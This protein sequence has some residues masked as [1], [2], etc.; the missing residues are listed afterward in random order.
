MGVL[1]RVIGVGSAV[2]LVIGLLSTSVVAGSIQ[3]LSMFHTFFESRGGSVT[4]Q[5]GSLL[6]ASVLGATHGWLDFS[7][8]LG[9]VFVV[10]SVI[11]LYGSYEKWF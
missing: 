4:L 1:S 6:D 7:T 10:L 2:A 8:I 11:G 9:I 5:G 3:R